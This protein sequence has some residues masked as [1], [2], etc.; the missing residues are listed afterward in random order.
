VIA[1]SVLG[2]RL[3]Y[4]CA[5]LYRLGCHLVRLNHHRLG[6][7]PP[8]VLIHG[9]GS[10]WQIWEPV[11]E[12][13]ARERDVVAVDLP[14]FGDSPMAPPGTPPG[15]ASLARLLGEFLDQLGLERPHVAGNS[16]GGWV[17][18]ELAR[19]GRVS[20]AT[21]VSPAGFHTAR[22]AT[23]QRA[24]LWTSVRGA[25]LLG[26]RADA[27]LAPG[28]G[29]TLMLG[30]MAARPARIPPADA[31]ASLRALAA[32][33]W[34]DATLRTITSEPFSDGEQIRVP[35]TI[36]WG[37]KD[38]L[39]LPRQ[40]ARAAQAIPGARLVWLRGCGHVPMYDDPEQVAQVLLAGS[41]T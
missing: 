10:R 27:V 17:S 24:S 21:G 1:A 40:A 36:A 22:E 9:I 35:V 31:A 41:A 29:R 3:L 16:L 19:N 12:R 15:P 39:L 25:R 6:V 5:F 4:A 20:T 33:P 2:I 11:L 30:Q 23:F 7:G 28:L 8:L 34:F 38:R 18:L 32:A 14:G 13:L 26:P 37:E